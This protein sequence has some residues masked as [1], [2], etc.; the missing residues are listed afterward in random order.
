MEKT[1]IN[2]SRKMVRDFYS[3]VILKTIIGLLMID[4][5]EIRS[6]LKVYFPVDQAGISDFKD[7]MMA[8][9]CKSEKGKNILLAS[10]DRIVKKREDIVAEILKQYGIEKYEESTLYHDEMT[11]VFHEHMVILEGMICKGRVDRIIG[12]YR[13]L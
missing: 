1:Y 12:I 2:A 4:I 13:G 10:L 9:L 11:I 6:T 7:A 8:E 5:Y 3:D